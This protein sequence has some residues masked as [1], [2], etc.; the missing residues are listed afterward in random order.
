MLDCDE[1]RPGCLN[2]V[3]KDISRLYLDPQFVV[4]RLAL[5]SKTAIEGVTEEAKLQELKELDFKLDEVKLQ[6]DEK[7]LKEVDL[8]DWDV[9]SHDEAE[10]AAHN[11]VGK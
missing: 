5:S 1:G 8:D 10:E 7:G 6:G 3:Q 2:C 4:P 11:S 9:I